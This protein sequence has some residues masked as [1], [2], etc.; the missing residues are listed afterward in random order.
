MVINHV[1]DKEQN[2]TEINTNLTAVK[3]PANASCVC[4]C[5]CTCVCL[6]VCIVCECVCVHA[7]YFKNLQQYE[8]NR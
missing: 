2:T 5:V 7:G 1:Y 3:L 8:A 6:C 4:Q